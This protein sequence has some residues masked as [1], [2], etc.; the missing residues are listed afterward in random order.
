M[1]DLF[2][3]EV[4][5]SRGV[6]VIIG[7]DDVPKDEAAQIGAKLARLLPLFMVE[8]DP[9]EDTEPCPDCIDPE[10]NPGYHVDVDAGYPQAV[11]SP[12]TFVARFQR[13]SR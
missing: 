13:V 9:A 11:H 12:A 8:P 3:F 5:T 4:P 7:P 10:H 1:S 2:R 6:F